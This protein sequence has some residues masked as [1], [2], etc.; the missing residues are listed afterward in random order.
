MAIYLIWKEWEWEWQRHSLFIMWNE[1][2]SSRSFFLLLSHLV[3]D[4][5]AFFSLFLSLPDISSSWSDR[6]TLTYKREKKVPTHIHTYI[7]TYTLHTDL[8]AHTLNGSIMRWSIIYRKMMQ[9][10]RLPTK[11]LDMQNLDTIHCDDRQLN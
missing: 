9:S 10:C 3:T 5:D 8:L 6:P 1:S 4:V 11:G 7:H 2:H